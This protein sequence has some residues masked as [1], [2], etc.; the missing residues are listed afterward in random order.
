LRRPGSVRVVPLLVSLP[1]D[2]G[3]GL[4]PPGRAQFLCIDVLVCSRCAT[5]SN[6]RPDPMPLLPLQ[7]TTPSPRAVARPT[8]GPCSTLTCQG[9]CAGRC[10]RFLPRRS[11]QL[12]Y[13]TS[14][15]S[16]C[17]GKC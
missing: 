8:F 5:E 12:T 6:S 3:G 16:A 10:A 2:L 1:V 7:R 14:L 13:I 17:Q 9:A 15:V 4:T 11:A